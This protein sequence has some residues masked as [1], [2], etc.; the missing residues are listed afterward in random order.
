M[1]P[2][3]A[4]RRGRAHHQRPASSA[5]APC[6]P[7]WCRRPPRRPG[8]RPARSPAATAGARHQGRDRRVAARDR[9]PLGNLEQGPL[10]GELGQPVGPGTRVRRAVELL[11]V[12]GVGE[13]EVGAA[14][15]HHDVVAELLGDRTRLAVRQR[16]EHDVVPAQRFR[17]RRSLQHP[18]GQRHQVGLE[19]AEALAGVGPGGEGADLDLGMGQE[20]A[21]DL[22][23]GVPAGSGDGD[24]CRGHVHDYTED[25]MQLGSACPRFGRDGVTMDIERREVRSWRTR[26]RTATPTAPIGRLELPGGTALRPLVRAPAWTPLARPAL[27]SPA[28][29]RRRSST[30]PHPRRCWGSTSAWCSSRASPAARRRSGGSPGSAPPRTPPRSPRSWSQA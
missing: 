22:S 24:A 19:R 23:P 3:H 18:V 30:A 5:W 9:D 29:S 28:R 6:R 1:R 2:A 21:Q 12:L 17:F 26:G 20:Q 4:V 27:R 7:R 25:C 10:P 15:D 16:Q 8:R 14:V 11:P 13:P